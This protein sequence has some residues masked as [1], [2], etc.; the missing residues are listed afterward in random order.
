MSWTSLADFLAMGGRAFYVWG[1]YGVTFLLVA[2]ELRLLRQRRK[3]TLKRLQR[4][5]AL[6]AT[7]HT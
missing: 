3:E 7:D 4:L 5:Q 2:L 1:A 6:E